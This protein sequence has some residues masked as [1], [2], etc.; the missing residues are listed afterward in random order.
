MEEKVKKNIPVHQLGYR[1][2]KSVP[3]KMLS[4]EHYGKAHKKFPNHRHHFYEVIIVKKGMGTHQIDFEKYPIK[5]GMLYFITPGQVHSLREG[6][7][8]EGSVIIFDQEFIYKDQGDLELLH[9]LS[10]FYN[11]L[12]Y[13]AIS[14]EQQ[15]DFFTTLSV[16]AKENHR[17]KPN[18]EI[19]RMGMKILLIQALRIR[20]E[21]DKEEEK[22]NPV[23]RKRFVQ[24]LH[25]IE[26][27]FRK[28]HKVGFYADALYLHPKRLHE[29][30][31]ELSG[32]TPHSLISR[33]LITEAK[34]EL[35]YGEQSVKET[36][37]GL[38]FED[39]SYFSKFFKKHTGLTPGQFLATR[40]ETTT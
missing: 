32:A 26:N 6:H 1:Q 35:F 39:V 33:R 14:E 10:L 16:L 31:I 5:D 22:R 38:G 4:L 40:P 13:V 29:L 18:I 11:R 15:Q 27:N 37:Y 17:S 28:E 21:E 20:Q 12:P 36:A 25:L 9:S 7:I 23:Y 34:R 2:V 19:L 8:E 24:L 30:T 3:F